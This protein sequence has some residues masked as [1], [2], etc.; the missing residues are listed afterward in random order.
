MKKFLRVLSGILG[1]FGIGVFSLII[2]SV[3][4]DLSHFSGLVISAVFLAYGIGGEKVI[5]AVLPEL[6]RNKW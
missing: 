5:G 4:V 3:G 2:Y 1:V 6:L